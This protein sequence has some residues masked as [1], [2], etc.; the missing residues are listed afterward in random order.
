[1]HLE[2]FTR[3][4]LAIVQAIAGD[5]RDPA[6]KPGNFFGKMFAGTKRPSLSIP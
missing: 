5:A 1:V 2:R 6:W 3:V 4:N